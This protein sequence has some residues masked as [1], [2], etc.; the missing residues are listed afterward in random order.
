MTPDR[1]N[2]RLL[3]LVMTTL[4]LLQCQMG[5]ARG[6][7][8][9]ERRSPNQIDQYRNYAARNIGD[10]L[11]ILINESTDVENRDE[12]SLDKTGSSSF[13][14]SLN[15]GVGGGLGTAI[16]N[17]S[18]G[19]ATSS[20]R[21]FTGDTEFRSERQ[22]ADRFTVSVVDVLPNG[23]LVVLGIR[24]ITVQGDTRELQL[25]GIV[26]PLDV[27]GGNLVSSRLVANLKIMLEARGAEESF[28][29]QGWLSRKVNRFWPF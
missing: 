18:L 28:N 10:V 17:A 13:D 7:G 25:S 29:S 3:L 16:G 26:R 6:Q 2:R 19:D 24:S 15:Y 21:E 8:L 14:G 27:L 22:F 5:T 12:R 1:S 11:T 20:A 4:A 23:N 9:F